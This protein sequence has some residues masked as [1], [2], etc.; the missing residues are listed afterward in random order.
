MMCNILAKFI[1]IRATLDAI[2]SKAEI[3]SGAASSLAAEA[4]PLAKAFEETELKTAAIDRRANIVVVMCI[5]CCVLGKD[6]LPEPKMD[7][8]NLVL[9]VGENFSAQCL[10]R[11]IPDY[12]QSRCYHVMALW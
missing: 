3:P 6:R 10:I 7:M 9:V 1:Y 8:K 5:G 2:R 11:C 4:N 12:I